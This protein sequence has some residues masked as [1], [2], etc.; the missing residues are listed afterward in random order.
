MRRDNEIY[1]GDGVYASFDGWQICLRAPRSHGDDFVFLE[2]DVM[3][4]LVS[5]AQKSRQ[6]S[7]VDNGTA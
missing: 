3:R 5:F 4:A 1:L 6:I 7:E 2:P